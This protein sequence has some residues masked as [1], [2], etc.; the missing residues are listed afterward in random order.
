MASSS[1]SSS[2]SAALA[3]VDQNAFGSRG[4]VRDSDF[5]RMQ[6]SFEAWCR[7]VKRVEPSAGAKAELK[8]LFSQYAEDFNTCTL[9]AER[10]YDVDRDD[11]RLR[12]AAALL[13]AGGAAG[14]AGGGATI[15]ELDRARRRE[16]E[17]AAHRREAE[18]LALIRASLN[19]ERRAGL[20]RQN[21]LQ[22]QAIFAHKTGDSKEV[23]RIMERL[24]PEDPREKLAKKY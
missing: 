6:S 22:Q 14:G 9:P 16:Q 18:R 19:P 5:A 15:A 11:L 12:A 7:E 3:G 23:A 21:Q 1:S 4:I 13:A 2:S 10:Y 8:A 24:K 17:E 20:E